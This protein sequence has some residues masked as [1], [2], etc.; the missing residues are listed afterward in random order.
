MLKGRDFLLLH[1]LLA[2]VAYTESETWAFSS[3]IYLLWKIGIIVLYI[4]SHQYILSK[5]I[6]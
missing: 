5:K 1:N 2:K 4:C 3:N 6:C